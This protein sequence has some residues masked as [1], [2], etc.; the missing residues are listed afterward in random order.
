MEILFSKT[1]AK[2]VQEEN[3]FKKVFTCHFYL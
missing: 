1:R 3:V 2:L